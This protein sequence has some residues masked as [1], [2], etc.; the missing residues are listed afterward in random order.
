MAKV[1]VIIPIYNVSLF[2]DRC[3]GAIKEQTESDI[4]IICVEDCSED[5]SFN[6]VK[7]HADADPRIKVLQNNH[8]MGP[9]VSRMKGVREATGKY[10]MFCDADDYYASDA[11]EKMVAAIE[12]SGDDIVI[13]G[14]IEEG[15]SKHPI[16]GSLPKI[17][18]WDRTKMF[19]DVLRLRQRH[20]VWGKIYRREVFGYDYNTFENLSIGEDMVFF[21]E[22]LSHVKSV[23]TL[24]EVVYHY[25]YN[26]KSLTRSRLTEARL[27]QVIQTQKFIRRFIPK[28]K[29]AQMLYYVSLYRALCGRI[30]KGY[31]IKVLFQEMLRPAQD[32]LPY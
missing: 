3:L 19:H 6:R 31:S 24:N 11:V 29:K 32:K 8:N 1:S 14:Y 28:T 13:G 26:P 15:S 20:S 23:S 16:E 2:V 21:Y 17:V 4:E 22:I 10:I 5:T 12:K 7:L 18:H 27:R 30:V 25:F 9:M